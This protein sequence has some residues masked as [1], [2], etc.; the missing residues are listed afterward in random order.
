MGGER[1]TTVEAGVKTSA[2]KS[3]SI[4]DIRIHE[5]AGEVHFHADSKKLKVAIPSGIWYQAWMRLADTGGRF[6]YVDAE[7]K[8]QLAVHIVDDD[9][10]QKPVRE[11]HLY[12]TEVDTGDTFKSLHKFTTG[13]K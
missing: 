3:T 5:N 9:T 11:A 4:G 12:V 2:A 13:K 1:E 7:R 10:G 8:T 6:T